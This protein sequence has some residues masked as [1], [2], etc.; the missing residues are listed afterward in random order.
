MAL[1]AAAAFASG[2]SAKASPAVAVTSMRPVT[3]AGHGFVPGERVR[4]VVYTKHTAV[5][6]VVASRRGRFVV[7]Y[8]IA[9]GDCSAVRVVAR[10]NRGSRAS[11]SVARTCEPTPR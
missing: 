5:R 10:G 8:P 6:N 7:R 11:Y 3:V 2:A 4:V 1:A 9:L